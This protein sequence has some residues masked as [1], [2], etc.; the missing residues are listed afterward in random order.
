MDKQTF[1]SNLNDDLANEFSAIIQYI[2]YASKTTGPFRPELS[3]FFLAEVA[4][5]QGHAQF[6]AD[7]IITLGGTPTTTPGPVPEASTNKE[8]LEAVLAA[9]TAAVAAYTQRAQ[10]ADALGLKSLSIDLEDMIRDETNHKEEIEKILS[11]WN[12]D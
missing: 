4:D 1:I 11:G 7:K 9:E 2:T 3:K 10:E 5:E 6:L 8:M 12:L